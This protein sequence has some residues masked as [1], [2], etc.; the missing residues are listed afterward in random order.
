MHTASAADRVPLR[1]SSFALEVIVQMGYGRFWNRWTVAPIHTVLTAE[2]HLPISEREGRYG[3]G[4]FLGLLRCP[5]PVRG[6]DRAPDFRRHGV[7][8]SIAALKPEQ[9][10]RAL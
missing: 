5:Y 2:R 10:N 3:I 6:A 4:G 7:F 1:G 9:G 8:L